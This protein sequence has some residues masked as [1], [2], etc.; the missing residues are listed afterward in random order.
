[1]RGESG[2]WEKSHKN[3]LLFSTNFDQ[4]LK[5]ITKS[6]VDS[7]QVDSSQVDSSQDQFNADRFIVMSI[8]R[9]VDSPW[10]DSSQVRFIARSIHRGPIIARLIYHGWMHRESIHCR[11]DLSQIDSS[12]GRLI[13]GLI[14]RRA[15]SLWVESSWVDSSEGHPWMNRACDE[16]NFR[17][18]DPLW[19]DPRQIVL[20]IIVLDPVVWQAVLRIFTISV[21]ISSPS[22]QMENCKLM[23]LYL[24][25][26]F[27]LFLTFVSF[28]NTKK[29]FIAFL[30][31]IMKFSEFSVQQGFV[32]CF[33]P[34]LLLLYFL[35]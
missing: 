13:A 18:T 21:E 17:W 35:V 27:M 3:V 6:W 33:F 10:V 1:M 22:V 26:Q 23:V 8:H 9:N 5:W 31:W 2:I 32:R 7:S 29:D 28:Q 25:F 19:I 34:I 20:R 30:R 12:Q 11:V 24:T 16:S 15:N 4:T 14:H